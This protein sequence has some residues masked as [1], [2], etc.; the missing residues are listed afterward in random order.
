VFAL[1]CPIV[2]SL[3]SSGMEDY[4]CELILSSI[5]APKTMEGKLC[6]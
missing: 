4:Q 6:K 3:E 2:L 5:A 1:V